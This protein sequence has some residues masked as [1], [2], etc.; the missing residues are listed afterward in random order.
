MFRPLLA[1]LVA[2]LLL[3]TGASARVEHRSDLLRHFEAAGTA[4]T[5]VVQHGHD[6]V[7][8]GTH[9]SHTRFLPSSTFKIPNALIAIERGIASGPDQRY[10]G[11][12]PNFELDG[13]PLLPTVCEADLTLAIAFANSCIPIFQG[14]ARRVGEPAYKRALR[15]LRYGNRRADGAPLD[16]FWLEGPLGI[17]A[18]EQVAFVDRLRRGRLPGSR[19]AQ[20]QVRQMMAVEPGLFGKTGYVFTTAPRVGWWVGWVER[21]GRSWTFALNLDI[22]QPQHFAARTSVARA[23]LHDLGAL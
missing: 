1:A 14:I 4:G 3:P 12:N 15:A 2:A 10:P 17:S 6:T 19:R 9:R 16:A 18:R 7:V 13:K 22:T 11:P 8:V 5:M 21:D 23:V 20:R